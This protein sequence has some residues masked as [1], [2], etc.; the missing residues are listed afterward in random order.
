M[1]ET[2]NLQLTRDLQEVGRALEWIEQQAAEWGASA[3][4]NSILQM[5]VEEVLANV[6]IHGLAPNNAEIQLCWTQEPTGS[7]R[8]EIRDFGQPFNPLAQPEVDIDAELD[9][10][11]IGGLGIHLVRTYMDDCYYRYE[12]QQNVFGVVWIPK[13]N[14]RSR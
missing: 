4:T 9:D 12:N 5:V 3:K 8:L 1:S 10:R 11:S 7:L 14:D 13:E 2:R 6:V